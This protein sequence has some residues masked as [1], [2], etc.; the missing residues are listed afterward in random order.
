MILISRS[1]PMISAWSRNRLLTAA[2]LLTCAPALRAQTPPL[3]PDIPTTFEAPTTSY[4]YVKRVVMIPMRDG[5]KLHTVIVIPKGAKSAPTILTRTP[6][7]ASKRAERNTKASRS[8]WLWST[9]I[10]R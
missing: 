10:R 1:D 7:N 2:A 6:Y 4:D 5:V 9:L 8:S 3:T